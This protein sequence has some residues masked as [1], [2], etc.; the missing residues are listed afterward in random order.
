MFGTNVKNLMMTST[1]FHQ[2][3]SLSMET[4][5]S[6]YRRWPGLDFGSVFSN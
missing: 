1:K 5:S 3:L 2:G 4:I 6:F